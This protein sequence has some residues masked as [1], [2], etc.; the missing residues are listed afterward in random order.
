MAQETVVGRELALIFHWSG[1]LLCRIDLRWARDAHP[2]DPDSDWGRRF[3]V[4]LARLEQGLDPCW[5]EP[6]LDTGGLSPFSLKVLAL[7]KDKVG[8]G[9][10]I[11]YGRLAALA[12]NSNAARAVG[13]V[14]AANPWPLLYPCHR[15][16]GS[17]GRLTGFGPGLPMKE[18]LLALEGRRG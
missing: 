5:P 13:R 12:G 2:V 1:A 11:S 14:M 3:A 15:V 18:R 4:A 9:A 8:F 17:D 7:L 16:L 6:P 10:T